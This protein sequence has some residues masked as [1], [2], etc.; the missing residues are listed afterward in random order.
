MAK[1]DTFLRFPK[2]VV[3][4]ANEINMAVDAYWNREITETELK[5]L[6]WGWAGSGMLFK[7]SDYNKTVK[8]LCGKARMAIVDKLL[9][10]YQHKIN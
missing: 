4:L 9:A 3:A 1:I 7:G 8:R 2:T 6:L 10:G 5:E